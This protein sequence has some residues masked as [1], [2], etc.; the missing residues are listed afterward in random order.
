MQEAAW[1]HEG[2]WLTPELIVVAAALGLS[3]A[4]S[5]LTEVALIVDTLTVEQAL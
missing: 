5:G 2:G 4:V 1:E 3:A